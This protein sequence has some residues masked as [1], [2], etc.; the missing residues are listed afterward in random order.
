MF[1]VRCNL[2]HALW[3]VSACC[4]VLQFVAVCRSV[5]Q[6]VAVCCRAYSR[7]VRESAQWALVLGVLRYAS[8]CFSVMQCVSV[9]CHRFQ[10]PYFH[11][12]RTH[13]ARTHM[14]GNFCGSR[15][16]GRASDYGVGF[17]LSGTHSHMWV[18][19]IPMSSWHTSS[20]HSYDCASGYGVGFGFSGTHSGIWVCAIHISS[21]HR[22]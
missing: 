18:R 22:F 8:A 10:T 17:G 21:W 14:C 15:E 20:W 11:M 1:Q 7:L 16:H 19:N 5:L 12:S 9:W 2:L 13:I 3:N 4:S 6:C